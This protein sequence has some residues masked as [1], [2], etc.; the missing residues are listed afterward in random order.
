MSIDFRLEIERIKKSHGV[1]VV[2]HFYQRDEVFEVADITG[3]SFGTRPS[4]SGRQQ[5]LGGLLWCWIHGAESQGRRTP[6][7]G[8][9]AQ[10]RLLCDGSDD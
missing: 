6:K 4:L 5:P 7:E 9:D 10:N 3:D 8:F 2:A 1:T